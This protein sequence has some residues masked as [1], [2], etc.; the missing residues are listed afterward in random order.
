MASSGKNSARKGPAQGADALVDAIAQH[1]ARILAGSIGFASL[2]AVAAL[3]AVGN[4][5][6]G[7]LTA[8]VADAGGYVAIAGLVLGLP[9]L[10]YAMVT[11]RAVEK[12]KDSLNDA[13][14]NALSVTKGE[15]V[16]I[17][18]RIRN[19][20]G[21]WEAE[22]PP[23]HDLQV[24]VP[25]REQTLLLPIYDPTETGPEEG[26]EIDPVAPQ[27]VTG[28]AWVA[29]QYLFALHDRLN[30]PALRL[31]PEQHKRYAPLTGVAA[32]PIQNEQGEPIGVLTIFSKGEDPQMDDPEFI[33]LH[34]AL[35]QALSPV[36]STYVAGEGPLEFEAIRPEQA[37]GRESGSIKP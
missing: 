5:S 7:Q 8:L 15:L 30:D 37:Q 6:G 3:V 11:D 4:H 1:K 28:S 33:E 20:L 34:R 14:T 35:A 17:R 23:K 32:A 19:V 25:N 13:L 26:W 36:V 27:A 22:V 9:A 31:T 18:D 24:F 10:S 2:L 16:S 29:N 21:T 12:L